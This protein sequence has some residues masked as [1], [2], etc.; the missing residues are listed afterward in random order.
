MQMHPCTY[1]MKPG[2]AL[3]QTC[4]AT[5]RILRRAPLAK[6]NTLEVLNRAY[7]PNSHVQYDLARYMLQQRNRASCSVRPTVQTPARCATVTT[8]TLHASTHP[9]F[10]THTSAAGR[11][12]LICLFEAAKRLTIQSDAARQS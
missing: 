1:S 6:F 11:G 12:D 5:I 9:R 3:I 4:T 10:W 8:V 7:D 2:A